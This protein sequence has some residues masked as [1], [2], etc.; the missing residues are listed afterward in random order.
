M[1]RTLCQITNTKL[2]NRNSLTFHVK[3]SVNDIE[4]YTE[5]K[6][7]KLHQNSISLECTLSG[8]RARLTLKFGG[9]LQTEKTGPGKWEW[10]SHIT[11]EDKTLN[12]Y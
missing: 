9:T 4:K 6:V 3:Y 11:H 10:A 2:K 8:C 1:P 5:Y 12:V 7:N